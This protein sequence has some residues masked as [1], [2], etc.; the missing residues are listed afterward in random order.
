MSTIPPSPANV[1][2]KIPNHMA[3]AIVATVLSFVICCFS[4]I[5][6]AGIATGIVAI[7]FANKV[8]GLQAQGQLDAAWQASRSAKIWSWVTTGILIAGLLLFV[9]NLIRVGGISGYE[10]QLEQ[11]R[12]QIEA[13]QSR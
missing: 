3:W 2:G 8:N 9:V 6:I 4:C 1:A 11:I 12:Q 7:V 13:A 10:Q 5:S